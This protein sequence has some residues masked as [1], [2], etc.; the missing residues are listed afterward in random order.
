MSAGRLARG[1]LLVA[2]AAVVVLAILGS[3]EPLAYMGPLLALLAALALGRYPG[4]RV[5]LHFLAPSAHIRRLR[6]APPRRRGRLGACGPR[7]G[8]LLSAGLAGRAPPAA[9]VV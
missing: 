2:A 7:G 5:L 6:S 9:T 8:A 1:L 4:E 3:P